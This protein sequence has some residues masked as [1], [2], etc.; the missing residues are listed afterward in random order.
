MLRIGRRFEQLSVIGNLV[1]GQDP[2]GT[3]AT[4]RFTPRCSTNTDRLL[5]GLDSRVRFAIG[6]QH[7]RAATTEPVFDFT[8]G[9]LAIAATGPVAI[10]AQAGPSAFELSGGSTRW[11]VAM[12]AG[13]GGAY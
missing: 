1:Y 12:L 4:A 10:F 9:P 2:E 11:G 13:L 7:G 3:S 8:G 5:Y 6:T